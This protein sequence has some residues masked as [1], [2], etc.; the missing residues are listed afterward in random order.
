MN[1]YIE[2]IKHM[3]F[4]GAKNNPPTIQLGQ[5]IDEHTLKL[6]DLQITKENLLF[7]DYLLTNGLKVGDIVAVM[8]TA[9]RQMYIVLCRVVS[10]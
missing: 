5:M 7:A 3:Q 4:E 8:P 2:I 1:P 6:G 9:D 10:V